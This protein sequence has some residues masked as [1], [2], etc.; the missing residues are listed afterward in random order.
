MAGNHTNVFEMLEFSRLSQTTGPQG[1]GS[2]IALEG[3][4]GVGKTS[5]IQ[6]Y[7]ESLNHYLYVVIMAR[8]PSPDV[9][10]FY[11]PDI[12]N[13]KVVHITTGKFIGLETPEGYDGCCI[14]FDEFTNAMEDAQTS[15]Q[16]MV[17]DG[18]LG[19]LVRAP[20]CW[21]AFAWNPVGSNCGSNELIE[22]MRDRVC[23]VPILTDEEA[24]KRPTAQVQ[25]PYVSIDRDIFPQ[26]LEMAIEEW[27][28]DPRIT[29]FHHSNKGL[30]FQRYD[31]DA[32]DKQPSP[33]GWSAISHLMSLGAEGTTLDTFGVG[34][35]G[36][37]AWAEFRSFI[38]AQGAD[39][40]C[41]EEVVDPN[42]EAPVPSV[43]EPSHCYAAMTNIVRGVKERADEIT[44]EEVEAVLR[45][46]RRLPET[47]AAYGWMIAKKNNPC[48]VERSPEVA[49][50]TIDYSDCIRG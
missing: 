20:N 23:V 34:R 16:S 11:V 38:N 9:E 1:L 42:I 6:Q 45:Y 24:G 19:D 29:G 3:P 32:E 30:H 50:F 17:Q 12:P 15:V 37:A 43:I 33:R 39:I 21:Y 28:I 40:P 7:C 47:F 4:R 18:R 13:G 14:F 2:P 49:A 10:G 8:T 27:N 22:S 5:M 35:V 41:Y 26:W 46:F 31:P 36:G 25:D 44:K 48:F